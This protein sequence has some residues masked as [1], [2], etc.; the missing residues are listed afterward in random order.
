MTYNIHPIFVHFPI[1]LLLLY[2]FIKIV[3]FYKWFPRVAWKQ[4]EIVLLIA[5]VLGAFVSNSTGE[6]AEH[7]VRPDHQLVEMHAAFASASTW[8]Y[9]LLLVGELLVLLIPNIIQKI[10]LPKITSFLTSI[11]QILT[12]RV[13]SAILA[14]LGLIAISVTGLLGGVMVYGT[15]ADPIAGIVLQILGLSI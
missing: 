9:A 6:I 3:P 11:Q 1:A 2:S 10:G 5:G 8:I 14:F 15:T 13:L 4:T 7:L 12:H